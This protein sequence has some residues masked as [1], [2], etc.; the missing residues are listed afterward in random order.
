MLS[1][2][3]VYFDAEKSNGPGTVAE[4]AYQIS[5]NNIFPGIKALVSNRDIQTR[6]PVHFDCTLF[7]RLLVFEGTDACVS[8][9]LSIT[10]VLQDQHIKDRQLLTYDDDGRKYH[11]LSVPKFSDASGSETKLSPVTELLQFHLENGS[12][13]DEILTEWCG[14][15]PQSVQELKE[16]RAAH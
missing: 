5:R 4:A 6:I 2:V 13:T 3:C 10:D 7:S 15:D 16:A 11:I 12:H 1:I 9:V 8:P 14:M